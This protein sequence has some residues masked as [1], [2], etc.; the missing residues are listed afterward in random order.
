[1]SEE[2][3][4]TLLLRYPHAVAISRRVSGATLKIGVERLESC[5][6]V[7]RRGGLYRVTSR[8]I[9]ALRLNQSLRRSLEHAAVVSPGASATTSGSRRLMHHEHRQAAVPHDG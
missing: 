1:M 9:G 3:L 5:G 6:L 2:A 7:S 4:L 8:G